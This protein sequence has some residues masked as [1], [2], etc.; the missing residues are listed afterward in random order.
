MS[1]TENERFE[2]RYIP[3]VM[4][5]MYWDALFDLGEGGD[6]IVSK[7]LKGVEIILTK[8]FGSWPS[9]QEWEKLLPC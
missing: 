8:N 3:E 4:P 1:P 9:D 6:E 5:V 2:N 7:V